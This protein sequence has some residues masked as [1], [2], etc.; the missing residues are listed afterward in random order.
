MKVAELHITIGRNVFN[1]TSMGCVGF[2]D[3]EMARFE[4]DRLADLIKRRSERANDVEKT[5]VI[6]G[7]SEF[8]CPLDEIMAVGF[9]DYA[10]ANEQ[11]TGV[12]DAFPNLFK[13]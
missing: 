13:S 2:D 7:I 10:K 1:S 12:K 11:E 9:V 3:V 4:F 6:S 5:I 8:T